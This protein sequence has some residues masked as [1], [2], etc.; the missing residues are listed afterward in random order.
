VMDTW[1]CGHE[2]TAENTQS[3][4]SAGKRCRQCRRVIAQRAYEYNYLDHRMRYLPGAI[5]SAR[6]KLASLEAEA[7]TLGMEDLLA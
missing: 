7:R 4:G 5:I 6:R 3:V 1:P 2:R